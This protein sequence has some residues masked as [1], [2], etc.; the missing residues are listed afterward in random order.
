L[1]GETVYRISGDTA[2]NNRID[3]LPTGSTGG[4]GL[5]NVTYSELMALITSS[6][7]TS[8]Q[9]YLITDY[10]T[11]HQIPNTGYFNTGETEPL[12]VTA[13]YSSNLYPEAYST[14]YPKDIIYYDIENN[15]NMIKGCSKG[16]IYRRI[17][18]IQNNDI[19]FDFRNVKFRRWQINVEN[20]WTDTTTW[21]KGTTVIENG[22]ST[23]YI[24]LSDMVSG[25]QLTDTSKWRL[26]E[27]DNL[28]Y[29]SPTQNYWATGNVVIPCS[30][31]FVDY[32]LFQNY[33]EMIYSNTIEKNSLDD[34]NI[35]ECNNTVI[36]GLNI[37]NNNI[38]R[39]FNYNTIK[40][41]FQ[42]NIGLFYNNSISDSFSENNNINLLNSIISNN[43]TSNFGK[44]INYCIIGTDFTNNN[45][46][47]DFTENTIGSNFTEN[48]IGSN[49]TYLI[50][51]NNFNNNE[52]GSNN[53][54][55]IIGADF[56]NNEINNNIRTTDFSSVSELYNK[57]YKHSISLMESS[58]GLGTIKIEWCD[59]YSDI[60]IIEI[61]QQQT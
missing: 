48:T 23:I 26:F 36:F 59:K 13:M 17:D 28:S 15:Q 32:K 7:L 3:N 37:Y 45:I 6:G 27:W 41:Y 42:G 30:A 4:G 52:I 38:G 54:N 14:L 33:N 44:I 60:N 24:A 12:I 56:K 5:I 57:I 10:Q 21:G 20:I 58:N 47:S 9:Q 29:I 43:F 34:G 1:T 22:G 2:I 50:I 18:T 11:I 55:N 19:P 35:L 49:N 39:N 16:Y 40:D 25:V 51:G 8:G 61:P 46:V 31:E 53:Y